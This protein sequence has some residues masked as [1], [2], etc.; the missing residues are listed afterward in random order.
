MGY[1]CSELPLSYL[2]CS[3]CNSILL[4]AQPVLRFAT[5]SCNA[6]KQKTRTMVKNYN[7]D[8]WDDSALLREWRFSK[9]YVNSSSRYSV[10][11]ILPTSSSQQC[12][13]P[14]QSLT[15]AIL[16]CKANSRYSPVHFF[17]D[18]FCKSSPGPVETETLLRRPRKPEATLPEKNPGF[19]AREIPRVFSPVNSRV[20][21]LLH[22]PTT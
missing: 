6:A 11:H 12:S 1:F 13:I 4:I 20:P 7:S 5:S 19:H 3:F 16:S 15:F 18:N 17:S 14:P 8:N 22:F 2:F 21:E 9:F 10:V